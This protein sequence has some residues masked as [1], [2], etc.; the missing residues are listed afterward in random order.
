MLKY[1]VRRLFHTVIVLLG[2][3]LIVF[4]AIRLTGDPAT[5]MFQGTGQPTP[6]ALAQIRAA[7]GLDQP[8]WLQYVHF[9]GDTLSGNMGHSFSNQQ[10]VFPLIM[11]RMDATVTL[12]ISGIVV[13]VVLAVPIGILSAVKRGGFLDMFGRMFSLLGISFPNFW[14]AIMLI[15]IFAVKLEW[16]PASGYDGFQYIVL[17]ALS[18][19]LILAGVLARLIR[20]SML[21]VLHQ[22]Y[23]RTARA[24][25]VAEW[26][27]IISHALRNALIPTI[28]FL[29]LQF[30]TLLGGVVIL[31]QVFSLPGVGRLVIDAINQRDYPVVQGSVLVL[32]FLLMIVNLAVD[33]S[34]ALIDPRI[35]LGRGRS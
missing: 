10:A 24:K 18:L 13:A 12:A 7:L 16:L 29:G 25:G 5:A 11:E 20:S 22:H 1:L 34:Y 33:L 30:G 26:A 27:I 32:A 23:V 17:P 2:I 6:E 19:G 31:E 35:K 3:S 4:F 8:L 15:L 28:T 21:D 9:L 14:L